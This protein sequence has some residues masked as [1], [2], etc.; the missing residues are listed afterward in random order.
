[1][2]QF[3]FV[4]RHPVQHVG[5]TACGGKFVTVQP[6]VGV[7]VRDRFS[8]E[9]M[10]TLNLNRMANITSFGISPITNWGRVQET[11]FWWVEADSTIKT[12][13][14]RG[15]IGE[16]YE[17]NRIRFIWHSYTNAQMYFVGQYSFEKLEE[18]MIP[19]PVR[20]QTSAWIG[21][22]TSDLLFGIGIRSRN[23][24]VVVSMTNGEVV[25]T[26]SI[27]VSRMA[28]PQQCA[29]I[30]SSPR[31]D[32]IAVCN[33]SQIA[34]FDLS[35]LQENQLAGALKKSTETLEPICTIERPDP[36]QGGTVADRAAEHWV[37]PIV[38]APDSS[39]FLTLGLRNRV[40]QYEASSGGLIHEWGWRFEQILS[41]PWPPMARW[42]WRGR[43]KAK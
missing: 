30:V 35:A 3:Q 17:E 19:L 8:G 43:S 34:I 40:Q 24:P 6:F 27:S 22:L 33:G 38:F 31:G 21:A 28:I 29:R 4:P 32:R 9:A 36:E 41:W 16:Q 37:P 2:L 1:M 23:R 39:T 20:I 11:F 12:I 25:A 13:S 18:E 7:V 26:L 10:H 5:F 15:T 42:R 14:M